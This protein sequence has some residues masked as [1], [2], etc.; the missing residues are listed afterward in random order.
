MLLTRSPKF[1]PMHLEPIIVDEQLNDN[2]T[3]VGTNQQVIHTLAIHQDT[4]RSF[5]GNME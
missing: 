5:T 4:Y 2:D 3:I 1:G